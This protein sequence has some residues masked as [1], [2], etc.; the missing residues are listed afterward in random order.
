MRGSLI[1]AA[2]IAALVAAVP[3]EAKRHK[4][5]GG[6]YINS[7]GIHVH[8]PHF[9]GPSLMHRTAI[10][11]DGTVSPFYHHRGTCSHHHG[12]RRW[13]GLA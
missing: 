11:G 9:G 6:H 13:I 2:L 3:A 7:D 5:H 8:V 12:V 10:C 4:T 1:L